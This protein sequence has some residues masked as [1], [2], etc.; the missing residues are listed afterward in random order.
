MKTIELFSIDGVSKK[1]TLKYED[2][3]ESLEYQ[4]SDIDTFNQIV[5]TKMQN[6]GETDI[7][8]DSINCLIDECINSGLI[9]IS[10]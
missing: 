2:E 10:K 9:T 1:V 4:I 8:E 3:E 6:I 7:E 5:H